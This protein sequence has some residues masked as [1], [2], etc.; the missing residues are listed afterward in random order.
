MTKFLINRRWLVDRQEVLKSLGIQL[1]KQILNS[2]NQL[3]L[4]WREYIIFCVIVLVVL[5]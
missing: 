4:R 2:V 3:I 1:S 5:G